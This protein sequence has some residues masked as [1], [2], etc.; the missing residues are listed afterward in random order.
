M[1]EAKQ[2]LKKVR[3]FDIRTKNLVDGLMQGPYLSAFKGRGIEFSD[4]REY[5]PGDDIRSIDWNVTARMGQPYIKEF[6]EERD[7]TAIIVFDASKSSDF[8]TQMALKRQQGI[9]IAASLAM[10]ATMNNDR[11]GLLIS[12]EDVEKFIPPKK[13]RK[14]AL[15]II[16]EL[17]YC[18][19]KHRGTNLA[20]PLEFLSGII[21]RKAIVFVISDFMIDT[22]EIEKPISILSRRNDVVCIKL[23]DE[24]EFQIPDIGMIELED[25]ETGETVLV[26][27][28]DGEFREKYA[29]IAAQ[30]E[31]ETIDFFRKKKIDCINIST[32]REWVLD[33]QKFFKQRKRKYR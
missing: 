13:G 7:L 4:V 11:I 27:T 17:V 29:E 23:E 1:P 15:R 14:Q 28:S 24:R 10:S 33:M 20:K 12:T 22:K 8:G 16:R 6:V 26:D 19:L 31:K 21:K 25:N 9:E 5:V 32:S 3:N 30:K 2:I 18:P